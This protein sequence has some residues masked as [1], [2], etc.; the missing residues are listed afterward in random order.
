MLMSYNTDVIDAR[1]YLSL[2]KLKL[3]SKKGIILRGN[4]RVLSKSYDHS[5]VHVIRNSALLVIDCS[6]CFYWEREASL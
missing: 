6:G 5:G 4:V 2:I 1:R 3:R